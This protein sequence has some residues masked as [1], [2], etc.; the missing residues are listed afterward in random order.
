MWNSLSPV[1]S[2]EFELE[3][4]Y[5]DVGLE[6]MIPFHGC[7]PIQAYGFLGLKRFYFRERAGNVSLLVGDCSRDFLNRDAYPDLHTFK[8]SGMLDGRGIEG[9][10]SMLLDKVL[11][12]IN[13]K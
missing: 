3:Q 6:F 2:V 7:E 1:S 4:K 8:H 10:F 13:S 12:D 5:K 11:S 9:W